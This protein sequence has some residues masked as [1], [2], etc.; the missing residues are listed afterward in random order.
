MLNKIPFLI[1][2]LLYSG[3]SDAQEIRLQKNNTN[4]TLNI[5][6]PKKVSIEYNTD[7]GIKIIKAE[8]IA[9]SFPYLT[10]MKKRDTIIIDVKN[11]TGINYHPTVA[12]LY[13]L[14]TFPVTLFS[15]AFT[16]V[17]FIDPKESG[18]IV[19]F[20]MGTSLGYLDYYLFTHAHR[21]LN[22]K[23]KWSFY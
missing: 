23:T 8:A 1:F 21:K 11:I 15:V 9:Y 7:T 17:A 22:T 12:P 5:L 4:S 2:L 10:V 19:P 14:M 6:L 16:A 18:F 13:Y 20:L 3:K